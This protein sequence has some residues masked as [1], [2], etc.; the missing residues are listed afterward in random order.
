MIRPAPDIRV[1][2]VET[3]KAKIAAGTQL[4]SVSESV[5]AEKLMETLADGPIER[6]ASTDEEFAYDEGD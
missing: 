5:A 4:N 6:M 1:H 2:K 3:A